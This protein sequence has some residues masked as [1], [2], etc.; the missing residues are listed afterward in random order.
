MMAKTS[1]LLVTD[2][3]WF[4]WHGP[5]SQ[6]HPSVFEI[7]GVRYTHAEQY[8]MAEKA[9]LFHDGEALKLILDSD[10]P[11]AQKRHGRAV[12]NFDLNAWNAAAKDIVFRGNVAKFIQNSDLWDYMDKTGER[13]LV[14]ASPYDAVWGIKMSTTDTNILDPNKW[15]GTNWL[16][17]VL[18]GVR[19]YLR[20]RPIIHK[21]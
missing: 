4:F 16:G 11:I 19:K 2:N 8:M 6:H 15:K 12:K 10:D 9:R 5:F 17:E 13:T 14:E 20:E 1:N 3:Y 18:V 21:M 7:D